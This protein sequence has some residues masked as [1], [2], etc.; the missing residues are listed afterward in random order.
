MEAKPCAS[1]D[2]LP[3]GIVGLRVRLTG[4][5]RLGLGS[6]VVKRLPS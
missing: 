1:R 6:G 3:G 2:R 4:S 5:L